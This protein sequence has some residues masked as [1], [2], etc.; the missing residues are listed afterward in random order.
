VTVKSF[1]I[2]IVLFACCLGCKQNG[3]LITIDDVAI[4]Y[5]KLGLYLGQYD[6][7]FV[8]AYYGPD[9]LKPT[10]GPRPVIPKD[11]LI[12]AIDS[13]KLTIEKIIVSPQFDDT[14]RIRA[15]WMTKQLKAFKMRIC[16]LT[17]DL[18]NFDEETL[19]LFDVKVPTF[20]EQHFQSLVAKLDKVLPGKGTIKERYRNLHDKFT[21]PKDKVDTL[22]KT[23]LN[24]ARKRTKTKLQL[25]EGETCTL[26]F[27]SNKPWSGNN[28]Y[29][30][31]Y[32]SLIQINTD[33]P[34]NIIDAIDFA[35][36]EG[37]PGHHVYNMIREKTMLH[38]K[39]WVEGSLYPLFSP[40]S[41]IGE[42]SAEYG[43]ELA[44]P[45]DDYKQFIKKV[46]LPLAGLDTTSFDQYFN[47]YL[48][49]KQLNYYRNEIARGVLNGTMSNEEVLT[50]QLNYG[51]LT[52]EEADFI[53]SFIKKYR[54][55]VICYNYG[56]DL[57]RNYVETNSGL[58]E[59][60]KTHWQVFNWLLSNL[61][62]PSDLL[63]E[64][65]IH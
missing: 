4:D 42:G 36:H 6:T 29:K 2:A 56:R 3:V 15:K 50:W 11:S 45:R 8:D 20:N 64:Q 34:F 38:D 48:L 37:Y 43:I 9:S 5:V 57:V 49:K 13:M 47:A 28:L 25:P 59:N 27:V 44:F 10:S 52:K 21:I 61:V 54:S 55:Y 33:L 35:C 23:A 63:P 17:G 22:F 7:S 41:I 16:I 30:C 51:L 31:N 53:L 26:E 65:I 12:S 40:L 18:V 19:Q 24:E 62:T 60:D 14:I 46:L 32:T 1:L 58:P 39:G